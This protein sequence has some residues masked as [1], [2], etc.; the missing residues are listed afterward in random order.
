MILFISLRLFLSQDCSGEEAFYGSPSDRMRTAELQV[1]P[2]IL[3]K[4]KYL[5]LSL[6]Q[7]D[8]E[9]MYSCSKGAKSCKDLLK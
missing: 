3:L 2:G 7:S 9:M 4:E 6:K 1:S 5:S 8:E